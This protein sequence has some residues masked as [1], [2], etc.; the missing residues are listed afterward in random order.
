MIS[1][2]SQCLGDRLGSLGTIAATRVRFGYRRIS[3]L[4]RREGFIGG[5]QQRLDRSDFSP[6]GY[7]ALNEDCFRNVAENMPRNAAKEW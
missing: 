6:N 2:V 3:V 7:G 1:A 4:F 5:G